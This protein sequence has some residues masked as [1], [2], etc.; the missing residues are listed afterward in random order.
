VS[1]PGMYSRTGV[2]KI[3]TVVID[4]IINEINVPIK[5]T[6]DLDSLSENFSSYDFSS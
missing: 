3:I 5:K 4:I 1:Y 2:K 6:L